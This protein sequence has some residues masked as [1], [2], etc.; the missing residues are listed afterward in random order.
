MYEFHWDLSSIRERIEDQK[1][2]DKQYAFFIRINTGYQLGSGMSESQH[3]AYVRQMEKALNEKG[4]RLHNGSSSF[5]SMELKGLGSYYCYLHPMEWTGYGKTGFI[6]DL[7]DALSKMP[8]VR[9]VKLLSKKE[10]LPISPYEYRDLIL[11]N[12]ENLIPF[13]EEIHKKGYDNEAG[14][15]FAEKY[16]LPAILAFDKGLTGGRSSMDIDVSTVQLLFDGYMKMKEAGII[17][18]SVLKD[19]EQDLE[20]PEPDR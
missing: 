16:R 13:F 20:E 11:N 15:I 8:I 2:K 18:L 14:M 12:M 10:L 9:S 5:S 19:K 4:Y 1:E 7:K 17:D 3:D 6:E